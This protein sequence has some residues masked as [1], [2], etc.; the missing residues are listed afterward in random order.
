[1]Y[2]ITKLVQKALLAFCIMNT[3]YQETNIFCTCGEV[4]GVVDYGESLIGFLLSILLME[5]LT[6]MKNY[7]CCSFG[8][9]AWLN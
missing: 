5:I 2:V 9:L 7:C 8:V 1:M 3:Q 6:V 4:V